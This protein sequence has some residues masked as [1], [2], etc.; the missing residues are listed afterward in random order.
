MTGGVRLK[1]ERA[2]KERSENAVDRKMRSTARI[3]SGESRANDGDHLAITDVT[4]EIPPVSC[5]REMT[6]RRK[7]LAAPTVDKIGIFVNVR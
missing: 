1:P 4:Q 2:R 3:D 6:W 7:L 5:R